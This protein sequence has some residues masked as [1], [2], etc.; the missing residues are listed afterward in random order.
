MEQTDGIYRDLQRHLDKQ[1]VG[2]PATKSGAEIRIL[3]RLF[4][5]EEAELALKLNYKPTPIGQIYESIKST[6]MSYE[7]LEGMLET[8]ALNGALGRVEK[9][10]VAHFF[11]MALV[12][13]MYEWQ[14]EKL[15]P[16][17]LGDVG[18]YT[19][20]KAFGLSFL[21]TELPQMRTIP[22][23][24]SLSFEHHVTTY[25]HLT[26]V[27]SES[28]G[29]FVVL[30]CICRKAAGLAGKTCAQTARMET[31][32]AVGEWAKGAIRAGVGRA[33]SRDEALDI[34]RMN[35]E[36][37]LILQ[38]SN[39][40]EIDFICACCGCC[41]GMLAVLKSLP[42][43]VDFW[44][45]NFHA[46]VDADECTECGT[47]VDRCQ[48]SAIRLDDGKGHSVIDLAR[49]I[50]CGNCVVTCPSGAMSLVKKQREVVPPVDS[51]ALYDTIMLHK[52]GTLGKAKLAAKLM[53]K[54]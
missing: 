50:G 29:P 8:M 41:C 11:T 18:Q 5:P 44:A 27:L 13:G 33:V 22:V 10:G 16:E 2:F 38:P 25:D 31:C 24:K 34:A 9:N 12:V 40:Q 21:S 43:P 7:A 15:T 14:L 52:K 36:D 4:R 35:Q 3:K 42:R 39:S 45:T 23:E 19:R 6:G 28:H 53:L 54:T 48:L 20:D 17:F 1:A 47:C 49:C 46:T 51:E 37:G 26:D 30:E 32:M